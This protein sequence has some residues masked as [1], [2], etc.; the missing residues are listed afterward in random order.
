MTPYELNVCIQVYNEQTKQEQEEKI[1]LTYLGAY[2][3]RVKK[4]PT[5]KKILGQ[6]KKQMTAKEMLEKVKQLNAALGG[7]MKNGN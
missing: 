3:Q 7:E 1:T 5:L 2:W 6:E 4:M